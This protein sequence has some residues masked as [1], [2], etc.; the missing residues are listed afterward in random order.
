MTGDARGRRLIVF[1]VATFL[2]GVLL[3][4]TLYLTRKVMLLL[5]VSGL[6][7]VGL[8]PTVRWLEH[9]LGSRRQRVPRWFA[10]L[11]L[12]LAILGVI[13]VVIWSIVGPLGSQLKALWTALPEYADN[14]QR[15]LVR[16]RLITHRWTWSEIFKSVPEP[17]A[18]LGG[19]FGAVKGVVGAGGA[20]VLVLVLPYYLLLESASLHR[21]FLRVFP[22]ERRAQVARL[23][24]DVTTTV[25]A[26]LG[27]QLLLSFIIGAT[28]ALGLWIIGVPYFYV[29]ALLCAIGELI[30][31]IG[32]ILAA[33][34]AVLLGFT[35]SLNTGLFVAAYFGV[36]QFLENHFLVPRI[37]QRQVGLSSATVIASLL[38]GTELC[39]FVGAI[40]AV[41]TAAIIQVLLQERFPSDEA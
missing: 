18:A 39:G 4:W 25:G 31:V 40:L 5:Y 24:R 17:A 28:A 15:L 22:V 16:H 34:P 1:A 9:R 10:I 32:P 2:S 37:M 8:S 20:L 21:S 11:V 26:W 6:L 29:L 13:A 35:V 38:I 14:L 3:L 19:V 30:P 27:G 12:Y 41:P 7:A 33:I 23:T 36:Q